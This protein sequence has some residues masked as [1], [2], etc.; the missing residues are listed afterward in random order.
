MPVTTPLVT[1]A[2]AVLLLLHVPEG[3]VS[4][5]DTALPT[6]TVEEPLSGA[7][8]VCTVTVWVAGAPQ[9]VE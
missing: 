6:H 7:G 1:E 8:V 5:S 3:T 4:V 9:P 2:T